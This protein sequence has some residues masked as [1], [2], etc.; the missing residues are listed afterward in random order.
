M[1]VLLYDIAAFAKTKER[2]KKKPERQNA[3][4]I[5]MKKPWHEKQKS[6]NS[7]P[8]S[9]DEC[10]VSVP[11]REWQCHHWSWEEILT[12]DLLSARHKR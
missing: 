3:K 2:S 8:D 7:V 5:N 1:A 6:H 9:P 11:H 10:R 12:P 4:D